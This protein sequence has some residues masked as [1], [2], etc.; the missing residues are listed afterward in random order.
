MAALLVACIAGW[1]GCCA[2]GANI[3]IAD[4]EGV[5]PLAH[6][7]RRGFAEIVNILDR[8]SPR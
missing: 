7:R 8:A 5:T 1:S 4:R 3:S 6:A 2:A